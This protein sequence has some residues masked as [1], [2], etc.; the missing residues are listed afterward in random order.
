MATSR[1]REI[2][3]PQ[4]EE[5]DLDTIISAPPPKVTAKIVEPGYN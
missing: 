5:I 4:D 3:G 1:G 2:Y